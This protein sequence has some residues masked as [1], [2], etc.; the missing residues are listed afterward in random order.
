M[1]DEAQVHQVDRHVG[2]SGLSHVFREHSGLMVSAGYL[3]LTAVGITYDYL[4]F[5]L[6][7]IPIL[8]FSQPSD[9]LLA[10]F[11]QPVLFILF[12]FS[13]VAVWRIV[14]KDRKWRERSSKYRHLAVRMEEKAWFST[15]ILYP[16]VACAYFFSTT[17][18]YAK[19]TA[20]EILMGRGKQITVELNANYTDTAHK[21]HD[22]VTLLLGSNTSF[23]FLY[24]PKEGQ[25]K[26]LPIA[27][28]ARIT[29][30]RGNKSTPE[31]E[32]NP[33]P[34]SSLKRNHLSIESN[35]TKKPIH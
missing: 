13:I 8:N 6:F 23:V 14:V 7:H 25:V 28:I 4:F 16:L 27:S 34:S 26:V 22:T 19:Y 11:R 29:F 12:V 21:D 15:W 31:S 1:D 33:Q 2:P 17:A 32:P 20:S 24:S 5:E 30:D 18:M 3:L 10:G 9:F 35:P